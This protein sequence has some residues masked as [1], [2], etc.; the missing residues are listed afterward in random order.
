MSTEAV[1]LV[2]LLLSLL[3]G[4]LLVAGSGWGHEL[5]RRR[6]EEQHREELWQRDRQLQ[7]VTQ[8]AMRRMLAE[9]REPRQKS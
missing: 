3:S 7:R 9:L 6:D 1:G 2:I 8:E 4:G 5:R